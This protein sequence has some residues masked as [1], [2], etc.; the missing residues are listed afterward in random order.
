VFEY[1][2]L[3]GLN[4]CP[5]TMSLEKLKRNGSKNGLET[6]DSSFNRAVGTE[7]NLCD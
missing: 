2:E 1:G 4:L 7:A 6:K 5:N 3:L